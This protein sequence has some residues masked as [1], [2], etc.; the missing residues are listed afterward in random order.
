MIGGVRVVVLGGTRFVGPHVVSELADRGHEV[1]VFHSGAHEGDLPDSVRHVHGRFEELE[2]HAPTLRALEP[3]VVLDMVPYTRPDVARVRAFRGVAGRAVLVSSGDVYR[4]FGRGHGSEPGPPDPTPLTED[5]P[6]REVVIDPGYDKVGV[7]AEAS[8]DPELPAA[9]LR[10]PAVH[11]PGDTQHRLR[12]YVRAMA[13]GSPAIELDEALLEWRWMRG[14][15][16]DVAHA[17]ALAVMDEA[18]AGRAYNVAYERHFTEPEWI[19]EIA[20]VFGWHGEIVPL[21]SDRLP[22]DV[23]VDFDTAQQFVVDSTR[24]RREL[25]YAEV[26]DFDEALGHTIDWEL[27]SAPELAA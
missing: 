21:P 10:L 14:Y 23:R 20:R 27:A 5:S 19:R 25:G 15:V 18:S 12:R 16:K 24:I 22:A 6:L 9:L 3:D 13:D 2:R 26:V 4:A 8:A 1:T 17:I 7:E 11:G